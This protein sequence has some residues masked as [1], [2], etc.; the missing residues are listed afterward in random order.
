MLKVLTIETP[1][2]GDRSYLV[3]DGE[4]ALVIDPQRDIDRVVAA[5][6]QAGVRITHVAET[7]I[8]NDYVTGG[9]ELADWAEATYLVAAGEHVAYGRIPMND[10]DEVEVGRLTVRVLHTPGHTQHHVSYLVFEAGEPVALFTGGSLLYGTVGRTDLIHPDV[11]EQLTRAQFRSARRL[12]SE[13]P[14]G[15][16]V[17]P[18][19]GF[20]SFCSSAASSGAQHSS[21]GAE[22]AGNLALTAADED[23]FVEKLLSG[24]TAYPAYYAHMGPINR[25]GPPPLDLTRPA[26]VDPEEL[27]RRIRAGDWVVDLGRRRI[28]A[29]GHLRGTVSFELGNSFATYVGW[30]VPWE[31]PITLVGDSQ[32]QVDEAQRALARIGFDYIAGAAT[33]PREALAGGEALA[34]YAVADFPAL[35]RAL[36]TGERLTVLDVRRNDERATGGIAGSIHVPLQ[37]LLHRLEELPSGTLWV[38]CASGFRASIASSLLHRAGREV[39]HIDDEWAKA[40][41]SGVPVTGGQGQLAGA[42][43]RRLGPVRTRIDEEETAPG[44]PLAHGTA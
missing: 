35:A 7:H 42:R 17:W 27:R 4:V 43:V 6:E 40:E 2:L 37:E 39:V 5:A 31:V 22:R 32:V 34:S 3:H 29:G 12:A 19:H 30:V 20:G 13:L 23:T 15:V 11:T 16:S 8:H 10:G 14:D 38:H 18:T 25:A 21:I 24:L 44:R 28:F 9:V 41:G 36:R 33:G 26:V 1:G